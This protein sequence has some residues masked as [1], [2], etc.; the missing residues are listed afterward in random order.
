MQQETDRFRVRGAGLLFTGISLCC[1]GRAHS[2]TR[3]SR[4]TRSL[5]ESGV[6]A[7]QETPQEPPVVVSERWAL[8]TGPSRAPSH[9]QTQGELTLDSR[10]GAETKTGGCSFSS[11]LNVIHPSPH[12]P[13]ASGAR[14]WENRVAKMNQALAI[15]LSECLPCTKPRQCS[16]G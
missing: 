9:F 11:L 7:Q 14:G 15:R 13:L 3:I 10:C 8:R 12:K 2:G 1:P 5:H 16:R 4:E 6:H